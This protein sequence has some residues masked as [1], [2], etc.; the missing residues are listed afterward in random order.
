MHDAASAFCSDISKTLD[1]S[2]PLVR[3]DVVSLWTFWP[4]ALQ[5][6]GD[7][8]GFQLNQGIMGILLL[9]G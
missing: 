6:H 3:A 4:F 2:W 8:V 1:G 9:I 7:F 5:T